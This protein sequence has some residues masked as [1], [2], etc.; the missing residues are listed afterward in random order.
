MVKLGDVATA[1]E[2]K[3]EAAKK[4]E[5]KKTASPKKKAVKSSDN[6]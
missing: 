2:K 5:V 3:A 4:T 6:K 1:E